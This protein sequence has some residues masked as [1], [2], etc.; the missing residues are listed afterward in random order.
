MIFESLSFKS[1]MPLERHNTA[2]TSLATVMSYPSS[3]GVPL[4]RPPRPSTTKRSWRS[5][6]STQRRQVILRGSKLSALPW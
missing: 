1:S 5:F 4:M 6:M 2:M 3:R